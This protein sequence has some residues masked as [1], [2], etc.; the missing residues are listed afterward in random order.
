MSDVCTYNLQ[1]VFQHDDDLPVPSDPA[2]QC[3]PA[4]QPPQLAEDGLPYFASRWFYQQVSEEIKSATGIDNISI[5]WNPCGHPPADIYTAP[6]YDVHFYKVSPEYRRCMTCAKGPR[7]PS[8]DPTPGSQTTPS[9]IAFFD[10]A[11]VDSTQP[12]EIQRAATNP[13]QPQNTP[14]GFVVEMTSMIPNMGSHALNPLHFPNSAYEWFD[15]VWIMSPYN[16]TIVTY[17]TMIPMLF[18]SGNSDTQFHEKLDYVEQ[19][20]VDLPS[21][22]SVFYSGGSTNKQ[23]TIALAGTMA[24][25]Q[26]KEG[27]VNNEPATENTTEDLDGYHSSAF[28][29]GATKASWLATIAF[30]LFL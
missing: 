2:V 8:C 26:K 11:T 16:K 23:I 15:P 14:E 24:E 22:H 5:D 1:V 17:E 6:H 30:A 7:G 4:N 29:T 28:S 21:S 3:N 18:F 25:C 27:E 20:I 10:I 12:S 19:T 9:G 13:Q